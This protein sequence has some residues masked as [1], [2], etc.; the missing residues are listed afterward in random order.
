MS[1]QCHCVRMRTRKPITLSQ[2]KAALDIC[3]HDVRRSA[4]MLEVSERTLYRRM[5]EYGIK[6]SD[7][8][9]AAEAA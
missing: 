8:Y 6:R 4:E 1:G 9:E 5:A 2:I 7:R 3:N